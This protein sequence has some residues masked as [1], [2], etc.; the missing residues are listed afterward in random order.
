MC[1]HGTQNQD[2]HTSVKFHFYAT[3]TCKAI[4]RTNDHFAPNCKPCYDARVKLT[5]TSQHATSWPAIHIVINCHQKKS[6]NLQ[7]LWVGL[8]VE[9]TTTLTNSSQNYP[10]TGVILELLVWTVQNTVMKG[11]M[12]VACY[13]CPTNRELITF[14]K[15]YYNRMTVQHQKTKLTI[16][17]HFLTS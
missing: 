4:S 5:Y 11:C 10:C 7:L 1:I 3:V 16:H 12:A 2:Q 6:W 17:L 15:P 13:M 14:K 8:P 9:M